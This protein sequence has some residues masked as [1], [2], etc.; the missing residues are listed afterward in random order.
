MLDVTWETCS[1]RGRG[2][3]HSSHLKNLSCKYRRNQAEVFMPQSAK[4]N[5]GQVILKYFK[6][7]LF[8]IDTDLFGLSLHVILK[9]ACFFYLCNLFSME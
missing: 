6:V 8:S 3:P 5:G 1:K 2:R 7:D 9:F 4:N